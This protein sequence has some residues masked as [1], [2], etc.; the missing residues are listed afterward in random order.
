MAGKSFELVNATEFRSRCAVILL[1]ALVLTAAAWLRG[2]EYDEQYTLFL[3]AGVPRPD[4]PETVFPAGTV[5]TVQAGHATL[6]GIARD[7]RATDV[8]P[9][10]YFWGVS[11]WRS[12]FG[13]GLFAARM[14]SVL[15]GVV[16]IGMVGVIARRCGIRP[17]LAMLL[18]LGCY[19]FVYTNAI[20]RG[21]AAAQMLTL[22]G[23]AL[24][25][26]RRPL[27]AGACLGAACCCNYLAAFVA[28]AVVVAS[29]A[30]PAIVTAMPFLAVDVWFFA[31]QHAARTDQ[32]PP[33]EFW[34]SLLRLAKYQTASVFG[35]LPLYVDGLGRLAAEATIGLLAVGLVVSIALSRSL[36]A[37]PALRLLL[38]AAVATPIGLLLLGAAFDNTPIELRYLSFGLPFIGLLVAWSLSMRHHW[39]GAAGPHSSRHSRNWT[40]HF[41]HLTWPSINVSWT[42]LARQPTPCGVWSTQVVDGPRK[43]RVAGPGQAIKRVG[44]SALPL[45]LTIQLASIAGLLLSPRSMQPACTAATEAARLAGDGIVLLPRG[46]DGVGIVGA[47]GIE[48][49]PSL[50][51]LLVRPADSVAASLT[52]YHRVVLALLAQDRDS[53]ATIA[54]LRAI[55]VPPNWHRVAIGSNL[56]VYERTGKGE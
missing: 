27:L 48:A 26:G 49:P 24:L 37:S 1:A 44:R 55:F 20:A 12:I 5:A 47:F 34:P 3:T 4:W 21:F 13:P 40:A 43:S 45:I 51:L 7:L 35:G 8:H 54:V 18:T 30:W 31:A 29:G 14:L 39:A 32:F 56:E 50:P 16:S 36:V 19:G 22:C 9:P 25:L 33:F 28:V 23:V 38:A 53:T 10:L 15:C 17:A 42:C 11:L 52:P 46:N 41:I 2:A 6:A